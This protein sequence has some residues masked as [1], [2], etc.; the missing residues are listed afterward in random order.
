MQV[1]C[2]FCGL[3]K[4]GIQ[5]S[6]WVK[7]TFTNYDKLKPG[8]II[9]D[10][11]LFWFDESSMVLAQ[12]VGKDNPQRMRNYSQFI[13]GGEWTPLSKSDKPKMV[14]L[15]LG[16][17]FPE[18]AAIADSGQKHIV[19]RAT[20][21]LKGSKSGWVQFEE[22][23]LWI[24]P[25]ELKTLIETIEAGLLIFSK[26]EIETGRY[27]PN[28]IM[29]FGFEKWQEMEAILKQKRGS[30]L[31][32]LVIFLSQKKETETNDTITPDGGKLALDS[33]A[34]HRRRIQKPLSPDDLGAIREHGT[35]QCVHQQP[36][37]VHQL[38][39]F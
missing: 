16:N 10:D 37:E 23:Q 28:R 15:L 12:K 24:E 4:K 26:S 33:L 2:R 25:V 13:V 36:G 5:F 3:D 30:L 9:C 8:D 39:L 6:Y 21:N 11:C 35:G 22:N 17:P 14:E 20:R 27:F 29:Q 32:K 18:L 19:F 1:G 7:E 38:S 31:L 34:R